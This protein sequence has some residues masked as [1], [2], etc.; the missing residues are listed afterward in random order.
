MYSRPSYGL[1]DQPAGLSRQRTLVRPERQRSQRAM[2]RKTTVGPPPARAGATPSRIGR[3]GVPTDALLQ[4]KTPEAEPEEESYWWERTAKIMTCCI[5]PS[6]MSACGG[7]K[8]KDVQQAWREK[9]ALC[10]IVG[11]LCLTV[12]FFTYGL[13]PLL[14]P[15]GSSPDTAFFNKTDPNVIPYRDD[16]VISGTLYDFAATRDVLHQRS[17]VNLTDDWHG[18]DVTRLFRRYSADACAGYSNVQ[19]SDCIIPN[20]YP[21]SPALA[22]G[23]AEPCPDL[24]WLKGVKTSGRLFFLWEEVAARVSSPHTLVVYNGAV[25]N[26]TEYLARSNDTRFV[27]SSRLNKILQDGVG[28]DITYL[29]GGSSEGRAAMQCLLQQYQVGYVDRQSS[30]CAVYQTIMIL[31]MIVVLGVVAARFIMALAFHYLFSDTFKTSKYSNDYRSAGL[32]A[33]RN[34]YDPYGLPVGSVARPQI[35]MNDDMYTILLVTCYSEGAEGI[36]GTLESLAATDYPDDKKLLYVVADGLIKGEDWKAT[37]KTTPEVILDMIIPDPELGQALPKSYLAIADGAK[38]HNMA[39]VHAGYFPYLNRHVPIVLIEKCGTPAEQ[40]PSTGKPGNRG[41]RDSQLILM[42]FLS[43]VLFADRMTALDHDMYIKIAHITGATP[44]LYETILMVDADT[45]VSPSSLRHM[46]QAMKAD[47][48]IMGLCGETRIANKRQSWVTTI[49]VFEYYISHHLGKAFESVFGGV[50]C[51]PGCFCMYRIRAHKGNTTV[52]ILVNPDIVEEYSENTVDTLHKKNLLLLG[53][54]RFL[55]TLMLRSFP[56]RKM[57]FVPSAV[58]HTVVP[59]KFSVLLSQRRRWINSTV[60]NLLELVLLRDLCGIFC[61]SMQ[62]VIALELL[63]TTILPAAII[64]TWVLIF[65]SAV[66]PQPLPLILLATSLLLP[67]MLIGLTTRK[68]L[69]IGYMF[70]YLL[71]LPIWNFV[72]PLY[73]FWRFDDF[74]WGQT[75]VVVGEKADGH[76]DKEG[77]FE[78]GSV[79]LKRFGEWEAMRLQQVTG[80]DQS[81]TSSYVRTRKSLPTLPEVP[82]QAPQH[83]SMQR[84][85]G[86][87]G[88]PMA[89]NPYAHTSMP[90]S[91]RRGAVV[92]VPNSTYDVDSVQYHS[93]PRGYPG[94]EEGPMATDARSNMTDYQPDHPS[95]RKKQSF[96]SDRHQMNNTLNTMPSGTVEL[97]GYIPEP[98]E[99]P[100]QEIWHDDYTQQNTT[101]NRTIGKA[102]AAV[103]AYDLNTRASDRPTAEQQKPTKRTLGPNESVAVYHLDTRTFERPASKSTPTL[104]TQTPR[105]DIS[106]PVDKVTPQEMSYRGRTPANERTQPP[107]AYG[108]SIPKVEI[109]AATPNERSGADY[110]EQPSS[111]GQRGQ[112]PPSANRYNNG[113]EPQSSC[114]QPTPTPTQP[115]QRPKREKRSWGVAAS[116]NIASTVRRFWETAGDDTAI[117]PNTHRSHTSSRSSSHPF[118]ADPNTTRFT[119]NDESIS[120]IAPAS[121]PVSARTSAD[122]NRGNEYSGVLDKTFGLDVEEI[123][124]RGGHDPSFSLASEQSFGEGGRRYARR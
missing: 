86:Q 29:F 61:F 108:R 6:C 73:A 53:E 18:V 67:G 59:D 19:Q 72:L 85:M 123:S 64:S 37:G 41:K 77:E 11:L 7:M 83:L 87:L 20:K 91:E 51:L 1:E 43:R 102:E 44:E 66:S 36:R 82:Y 68:T 104:T 80:V 119:T 21:L 17:T 8:T 69:Y 5:W 48:K 96:Y 57:V 40:S 109:V 121:G 26:I 35:A 122:T 34:T 31:L 24:A 27:T 99:E 58:C 25:L 94:Y 38:Q 49:Q 105:G 107:T 28:K 120:Y 13:K 16:V 89:Q 75:R 33:K 63:G 3:N 46:N 117:P 111:A 74:S 30:G 84:S 65:T 97:K 110:F 71:A 93:M 23:P 70:I 52:P 2:L 56:K 45:I 103:S 4:Y 62:F 54:D 124:F 78:V 101:H 92:V 90:R 98:E 88:S 112:R 106:R 32:S 60:H 39:K 116:K 47:D 22:P 55:T 95:M 50:T 118:P 81:T 9:V 76:G 14:C 115:S 113:H 79:P 10:M 100:E 12:G 114:A 42:N 15:N